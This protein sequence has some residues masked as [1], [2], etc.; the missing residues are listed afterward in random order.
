MDIIINVIFSLLII[1]VILMVINFKNIKK[2]KEGFKW[3][4]PNGPLSSGGTGDDLDPGMLEDIEDEANLEI[5]KEGGYEIVGKTA[6]PK[7]RDSIYD[8]NLRDALKVW[9]ETGCDVT[10]KYAPSLD[11]KDDLFGDVGWARD[12]YP[13]RVKSMYIEANK[14]EFNYYDWGHYE[15][16]NG[17]SEKDDGS[18]EL[19]KEKINKWKFNELMDGRENNIKRPKL[20]K[21]PMGIRKSKSLCYGKDPGRYEMPK[22]GDRVKIKQNK[23]YDGPY[24]SGIVMTKNSEPSNPKENVEVFWE[25]KGEA[26]YDAVKNSIKNN[27]SREKCGVTSIKESKGCTR[28]ETKGQDAEI[29]LPDE[30]FQEMKV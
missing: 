19:D 9:R 28:D 18:V 26:E 15:D 16:V 3:P 29:I 4:A 11:N 10:S 8:H 13:F 22:K 2:Y 27:F 30:P 6:P 14:A 25:Q 7:F 17:K 23:T 21:Y 5:V 12:D 24:F 1:G 20:V